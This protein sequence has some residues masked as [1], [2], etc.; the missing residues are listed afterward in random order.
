M[1]QAN[2]TWHFGPPLASHQNGFT[3][4]FFRIV[5]KLIRSLVSEATLEEFDLLT[6]MT[7]IERIIND[8][9][10]TSLPSG[11]DDLLALTPSMVLTG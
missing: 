9:P 4:A 5:R 1:L 6:L 11:P 7:E 2:I 3:E 8:R 10:I